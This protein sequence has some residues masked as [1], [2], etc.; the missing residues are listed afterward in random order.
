[1]HAAGNLIKESLREQGHLSHLG[2]LRF[3]EARLSCELKTN[4]TKTL[5][6]E[7][8]KYLIPSKWI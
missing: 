6:S 4:I 8:S 5:G 1:M 3:N 7:E 2:Y